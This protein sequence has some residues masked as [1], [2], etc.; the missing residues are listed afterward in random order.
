MNSTQWNQVVSHGSFNFSCTACAAVALLDVKSFV[1]AQLFQRE[2]K[3]ETG[4][5]VG[6]TALRPHDIMPQIETIDLNTATLLK[7]FD[8]VTPR[9]MNRIEERK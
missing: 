5:E 9:E 8:L 2:H 3:K 6:V 4:H 1:E 7:S